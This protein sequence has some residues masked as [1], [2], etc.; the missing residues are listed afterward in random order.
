MGNKT[1]GLDPKTCEMLQQ[2]SRMSSREI[3]AWYKQFKKDFPSGAMDRQQFAEVYSNF[4]PGGHSEAFA[5]IVFD[6]FDSDGNG[7]VDFTEFTCALGIINNGSIEEKINWA[8]D[9]YD[10]DKN[11]VITRTEFVR[12][13]KA[14]YSLIGVVDSD[15]LPP[16]HMTPEQ[17]ADAIFAKLDIN[18]D[19]QLSRE[20][21][22]RG[23][24][25]DADIMGM[26]QFT[27]S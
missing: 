16:G 27:Q 19:G 8:F 26:L 3:K 21:F 4:F 13:L 10:Q 18:R 24:C 7:K 2:K 25:G 14:L 1:S 12:I 5:N 15:Q 22:V 20:E 23:A 9:L 17:H 11:G 6:N